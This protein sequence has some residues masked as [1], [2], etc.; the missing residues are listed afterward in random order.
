MKLLLLHLSDI[1][2]ESG[3]DFILNRVDR[4]A[5][6]MS[7][8]DTDIEGCIVVVTGDIA[9]SGQVNQYVLAEQFLNLLNTC[10]IKTVKVPKIHIVLV[11]GNHDCDFSAPNQ[12]RDILIGTLSKGTV[13]PVSS[14]LA[15]QSLAVQANYWNFASRVT[16]SAVEYSPD[17]QL[18]LITQIKVGSKIISFNAYNTAWMSQLHESQGSL[19][20][21]CAD[22]PHEDAISN[23]VVSLFHHPYNWLESVNARG[24]RSIIERNSDLILTGHEH[25]SDQYFKTNRRSGDTN[26]YVEGAVLQDSKS[27]ESSFNAILIDLESEKQKFFDANWDG[28]LY[29]I[30]AVSATW[31]DFQRNKNR[32]RNEFVISAAWSEYLANTGAAFTNSRRERLE[33]NDIFVE[34]N[35]RELTRID[36]VNQGV[37]LTIRGDQLWRR[38]VDAPYIAILGEESSGKTTLSKSIYSK[39][40]T[41]GYVPISLSGEEFKFCDRD[42]IMKRLARAVGDQYSQAVIERYS[43]MGP[44]KRVLLIDNYHLMG[45][46]NR[47]VRE[48]FNHLKEFFGRII[49]LTHGLSKVDEL[50]VDLASENVLASFIQFE[51]Q[52]FGNQLREELIERWFTIG[53]EF[54]IS[55]VELENQVMETKRVVDAMMGRNLL[56]AYPIFILIILQQIEAQTNLNASSGALGYLYEYLITT[57]LAKTAKRLD[58][59][60]AHAYLSEVANQMFNLHTIRLNEIQ[61]SEVHKRY[62]D[63]FKMSL[64]FEGRGPG[65]T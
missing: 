29:A 65:P 1:H 19:H 44:E 48:L 21:P 38:M 39:F 47:G 34:P 18:C 7:S 62:C 42:N 52:E 35:L 15:T 10:L 16:G 51:L 3:G 58:L 37:Q 32:T 64:R 49:I 11:P 12:V 61:M 23:L 30:D 45:L 4:I 63:D 5:D 6:A 60:T 26:E 59:D 13:G 20:F 25:E 27:Q 33:R 41:E 46:N 31:Q 36:N 56:P 17:D 54:S 53:Q 57:S 43:Q 9:Y 40:H 55:P 2:I 14:E 24:F 22:I 28:K 50:T 8:L